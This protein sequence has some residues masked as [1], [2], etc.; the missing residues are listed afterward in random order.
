MP[1]SAQA[2]GFLRIYADYLGLDFGE[3]LERPEQPAESAR[4]P[5]GSEKPEPVEAERPVD[6]ADPLS[7]L[8]R[9]LAFGRPKGPVSGDTRRGP[10]I[11][12]KRRTVNG[13]VWVL[14]TGAPLRPR[15]LQAT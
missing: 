10:G 4:R 14:R 15:S 8:R 11:E 7:A 1:S 5:A 13:I 2:R 3:L 6:Q 12:D 9:R